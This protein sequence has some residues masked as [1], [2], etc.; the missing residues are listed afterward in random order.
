MKASELFIRSLEKLEQTHTP[1]PLLEL[2]TDN[3]ALTRLDSEEIYG[4]RDGARAFWS[5]YLSLFKEIHSRFTHVLEAGN[6]AVLEWEA[7]GHF[8]SGQPIHYRGV[9]IVE[10]QGDKVRRFRTYYDSA[11]FIEHAHA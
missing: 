2:F 4:G 10:F 9:S 11:R 3:S 5:E 7:E 8:E 1:E 6:T